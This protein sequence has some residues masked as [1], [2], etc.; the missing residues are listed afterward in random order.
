MSTIVV[1]QKNG[2][3]CIGAD[4][5]SSLG[6][7]R[8]KANHIVNKTKIAKIGDTF[9]GRTGTSTSLVVMNSYFAKP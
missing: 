8:Q 6:S 3:A 2:V 7:L 1:A 5:M 4:T 9:I